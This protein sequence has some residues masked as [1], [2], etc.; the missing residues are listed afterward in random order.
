MPQHLSDILITIRL[1]E[2]GN[3]YSIGKNRGGASGAYQ[4]IDSTWNN[5]AGFPSSYLAP[6]FVQ[7]ERALADVQS[8]LRTWNNDVSMVPVIWYY[9]RAAREPAL[10][11]QVPMPQAGNRLTVREYQFRWLEMLAQVT[12]DS[13]SWRAMLLPPDLKYLAGIPPELE[14]NPASAATG[15]DGLQ[16]AYP[17]LGRSVVA[18]PVA[19]DRPRC[20]EGTDAIVYG[21]K[22][23][24]VLAAADG[25][26]TAVERANAVDRAVTVT[27]TDVEGRTYR[28]SGFNDDSPGTDDGAGHPALGV[29]V[30]AQV[31]NSVRA[32]QI[33]GFMGDSDPMPGARARTDATTR[34]ASDVGDGDDDEQPVWPHLRLTIRDADGTRLD[35]DALLVA[36]QTRQACHVGTGP[37]ALPADP[38]LANP[39]DADLLMYAHAVLAEGGE[40][41]DH[42]ELTPDGYPQL[43]PV[44]VATMVDGGFRI[45]A[46][47]TVQAYGASALIR[48]PLG[49][50]W[51]PTHAFGAG[52]AGAEA[53]LAWFSPIDLPARYWVTATVGTATPGLP[54]SVLLGR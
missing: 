35:A 30:L 41:D 2:S 23:Q 49:C 1:V 34:I 46:D 4:Y 12:G 51:A 27:V 3:N 15:F 16:V 18:P 8:I 17:V 52:A 42:P 25:V 19:C 6:P 37:W 28:Y 53:P 33:L 40:L 36:A 21:Q 20:E 50:E 43:D 47:G 24:P 13:L 11:D 7:D 22:L 14:A 26:V 45:A 44:D 39:D 38:R 32:G 31:G 10:M 9:P 48:H 5:Y 29:S 54:T